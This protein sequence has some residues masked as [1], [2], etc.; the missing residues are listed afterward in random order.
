MKAFFRNLTIL[1]L[2]LG[3]FASCSKDDDHVAEKKGAGKT[4]IL[5]VT[6][7]SS[8]P[9][10]AKTF[11]NMEDNVKKAYPEADITWAFTSHI[12]RNILIK[13]GEGKFKDIDSPEEA[14]KKLKEQGYEKIAV[15]SLHVIPG[16]EFNDL[17]GKVDAFKAANPNIKMTL[18]NPLMNT[19]EDMKSLVDVMVKKFQADDQTVVMMGHGTEHAA[20]DRYTRVNNFFKAANEDF[21]VGTV[22]AT[23]GIKEVK[24]AA[25]LR[26]SKNIL[27]MPLMSVAGDHANNDMAGEDADS[28][29]SQLEAAGFTV[30]P[31]LKGLGDYNEVVAIWVKHLKVAVDALK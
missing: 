12:I 25:A 6:F 9:E 30:T 8:Y 13:R 1:S 24:E 22:E 18:G 14:M 17:K 27:L 29:K 19:D 7:G 31:R 23:P 15:Q 20:N 26:P 5:L 11:Q 28:W 16:S 2:L 10:P 4:A 21:I 3:M